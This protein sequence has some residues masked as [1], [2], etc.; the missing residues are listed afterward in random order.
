MSNVQLGY[1][2]GDVVGVPF[3]FYAGSTLVA[4]AVITMQT[5]QLVLVNTTGGAIG[6]TINL[7]LNPVDGA[8]AEISNASPAVADVIT[9]TAVNA[10]T[11]DTL[12]TTGLGVPATI[13]VVASTS[14]GSAIATIKYKYTL[15]G[16]QPASGAAVSPRTWFRIQ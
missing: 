12:A 7:P 16:F 14:G 5:N 4:G 11:G 6:V 2:H 10:N 13:T 1:G 8:C 9:L 15:N 3:D